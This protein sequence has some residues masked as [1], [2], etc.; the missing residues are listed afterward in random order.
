VTSPAPAYD[1][2]FQE[3]Q[4]LPRQF[5]IRISEE[6]IDGR[7]KA[8]MY[9]EGMRL[10]DSLTDN[11]DLEDGYRFHDAF[12]LAFLAVLGWS[13]VIRKLMGKKRRDSQRH[14]E[15]ED[16]GRAIVIEEG[17]AALIFEYGFDHGQLE[18]AASVDFE[19][20]KTIKA[21]TRRLEVCDQSEKAW[22]EA[23]RAG[24]KVFRSLTKNK[25]GVVKCDLDCRRIECD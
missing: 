1:S 9:L 23:I 14:D 8:V 18:G 22:E 24:W 20:I 15:N 2:E 7:I 5:T 25:G 3:K 19:L 16:G 6:N 12:H 11:A 13:P 4:K 10:G 21:M 17:I